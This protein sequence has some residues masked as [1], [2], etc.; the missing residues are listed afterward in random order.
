M[1]K[2]SPS[3]LRWYAARAAAMP[4]G[5]WIH[6]ARTAGRVVVE[7]TRASTPASTPAAEAG[8]P[9]PPAAPNLIDDAVVARLRADPAV[10]AAARE[11]AQRITAGR[12][13]FLGHPEAQLADPPDWHHDLATDRHWPTDHW[14]RVD[15]RVGPGD[16]KWI[17][18]LGR[19]QHTVNLARAWRLTG[20][21]RYAE[22]AARH[23]DSFL[24]QNPPGRGI[25]W[26]VGLELG[27]RLVSF[28]WLTQLLS[29]SP[30]AT[31]ER[32]SAI[33]GS[34]AAHL[35]QL[36]RHPSLYS[37]ANN[38]RLGELMGL[39]VGGLAFPQLPRASQRVE[40]G[41]DGLVSELSK[42]VH[43]DGFLKEGS[44]AYQGFVA[45]ILI[46][47]VVCLRRAGRPVPDGIARPLGAMAEVIGVVS[48]DGGT[49]PA[50]GDDDCGLAI[51]LM[52]DHD[53][54][55]RLRSRLRTIDGLV[56][57]ERSRRPAGT[58]EQTLWLCGT[59]VSQSTIDVLPASGVF[60]TGGLVVLRR[61]DADDANEVRA[62]MRAGPFGLAPIYAH[63]HADQLSVCV[64]IGG[65]EVVIDAGTFTYYGEPRW[66]AFARSTGAHST[67]LVDDRDQATPSGAFLWRTPID[68]TIDSVSFDADSGRATAHHDAW[69]PIRH[70]R[71]IVL[72]E[73]GLVVTDRVVGPAGRH[74]IEARWHL[75]PGS[76]AVAGDDARWV[77]PP[78]TVTVAVDGLGPLRVVE[79]CPSKPLGYRSLVLEKWEPTPV[80]VASASRDLPATITTTVRLERP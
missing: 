72:D 78:G 5:E 13:S 2:L 46:P 33:L 44:L 24:D 76:V 10:V 77:G 51:D 27:I 4:P 65:H 20:D 59:D 66:R 19:H 6:R 48:S 49:L 68:A 25:H 56:D 31:A 16:P 15:H 37:S 71:R 43:P 29:E 26:R 61:R 80:L 58:D 14:S 41:L 74:R 69:A 30:A 42:Q 75:A 23:I 9:T 70:E 79:D 8:W 32:G 7:R 39:A 28:A 47:V 40:A 63:S 55:A 3:Q 57:G 64:S 22:A 50:I 62:V 67:I 35:D 12:I 36:E 60:P 21:D 11:L 34:V 18:E 73:H 54:V 38:H 17:W 53:P 52:G 45:D 1:S